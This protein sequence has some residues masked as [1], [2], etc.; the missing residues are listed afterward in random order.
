[1]IV[2]PYTGEVG[3][4]LVSWI[5]YLRWKLGD[6]FKDCIAISRGG[7]DSWYPC[8][9]LN[10]YDVMSAEEYQALLAI[11]KVKFKTYN[12]RQVLP[13]R[14]DR[15]ILKA[16][17]VETSLH[18]YEMF[19][20]RKAMQGKL[21]KHI[22]RPKVER[23]PGLPE[24]YTAVRLYRNDWLNRHLDVSGVRLACSTGLDG[25]EEYPE[26]EIIY[27]PRNSLETITRVVAHAEKFICNYGGL[28]WLGAVLGVPTEAYADSKKESSHARLEKVLGISP[29]RLN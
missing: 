24:K 19:A 11:R 27:E 13:D 4:E 14:M 10:A 8:K 21:M 3:Y 15:K 12:Q 16:F 20:A 22:V 23:W 1:M 6:K 5:P 2:G 7:T 9:V 26:G 18:P 17:G 28:S 25:H 29:I